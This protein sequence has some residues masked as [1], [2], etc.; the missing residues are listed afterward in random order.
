MR[1]QLLKKEGLPLRKY[2]SAALVLLSA[3]AWSSAAIGDTADDLT[4]SLLDMGYEGISISACDLYFERSV[5]PNAQKNNFFRYGRYIDLSTLVDI[6]AVSIKRQSD[7]QREIYEVE[8]GFAD[9]NL[10][11]EV[12]Q[13]LERFGWWVRDTYPESNYP[14]QHPA[15]GD[16][17]ISRVHFER[18]RQVGGIVDLNRQINASQ[19]GPY[20]A[21]ERSF[22]MTYS[23]RSALGAFVESLV[24]HMRQNG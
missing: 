2:V 12:F 8:F 10:E 22:E 15:Q 18:W 7:P 6:D 9:S 17:F 11:R 4:R 3:S 21:V 16:R 1:R 13:S 5:E 23:D 24:G 14:Y 19:Y 20:F